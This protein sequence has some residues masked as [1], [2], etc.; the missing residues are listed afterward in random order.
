M[1]EKARDAAVA[2]QLAQPFA[3]AIE[4]PPEFA[5]FRW[6]TPDEQSAFLRALLKAL[7]RA[8][9]G[10]DMALLKREVE[11]WRRQAQERQAVSAEAKRQALWSGDQVRQSQQ[12]AMIDELLRAAASQTSAAPSLPEIRVAL[13][14]HVPFDDKLSSD[15]VATRYEE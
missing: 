6:L 3:D 5:W 10:S 2:Y 15:I 7:A 13:E 14:R 11:Q 1:S 12:H 4:L 8:W 9:P